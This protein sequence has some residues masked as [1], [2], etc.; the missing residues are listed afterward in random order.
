MKPTIINIKYEDNLT[1]KIPL[2]ISRV[3]A[4]FPSPAEDYIEGKLDFNEYLVKHPAATF[5]VRVSGDSMIDAGIHR[6]DILVVDR[7][8]NPKNNNVIIAL[9]NDELTVK[10][11]HYK[12]KDILL[13]PA[14]KNYQPI[15][16]TPEMNFEVWGVV[17]KVIKD[18]L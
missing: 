12:D 14:N 5:C 9:I 6:N 15:V 8:L 1:L 16:I 11:L 10:I 18:V 3:K 17:S 7:A 13:L 2:F 4:G